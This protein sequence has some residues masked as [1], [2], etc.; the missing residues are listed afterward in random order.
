MKD[1]TNEEILERLKEI[2]T[3]IVKQDADRISASVLFSLTKLSYMAFEEY[4]KYDTSSES[5]SDLY[6][7]FGYLHNVK[8]I[9][10]NR[11]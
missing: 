9:L 3:L 5:N 7:A 4:F 10:L 1:Y 8:A 6:K 2:E 11:L